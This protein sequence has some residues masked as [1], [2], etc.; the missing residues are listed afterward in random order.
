[1]AF[2]NIVANKDRLTASSTSTIPTLVEEKDGH[3]VSLNPILYAFWSRNPDL[4]KKAVDLVNIALEDLLDSNVVS[5][6]SNYAKVVSLCIISHVYGTNR[7][8][9]LSSFKEQKLNEKR[10]LA[11]QHILNSNS[12]AKSSS[13][14]GHVSSESGLLKMIYSNSFREV[15]KH[16]TCPDHKGFFNYLMYYIVPCAFKLYSEKKQPTIEYFNSLICDEDN[17]TK[18]VEI[19]LEEDNPSSKSINYS[20]STVNLLFIEKGRLII[21]NWLGFTWKAIALFNSKGVSA[22]EMLKNHTELVDR[23]KVVLSEKD[24][25]KTKDLLDQGKFSY[26]IYYDKSEARIPIEQMNKAIDYYKLPLEAKNF[27]EL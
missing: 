11:I 26:R 13:S 1:M 2:I 9:Q 21:G 22:F 8:D 18:S 5:I 16:C 20:Y 4:L 12:E 6:E 24:Y 15:I 19:L 23:F 3:L 17:N 7:T 27:L 25:K 10:N 14:S